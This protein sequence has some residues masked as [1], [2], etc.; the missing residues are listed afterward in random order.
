[1]QWKDVKHTQKGPKLLLTSGY[2]TYILTYAETIWNSF[3][4]K[5]LKRSGCYMRILLCVAAF[6]L[7]L[8]CL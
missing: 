6:L 7:C 2:L 8:G 1:M 3:S 4:L 5:A